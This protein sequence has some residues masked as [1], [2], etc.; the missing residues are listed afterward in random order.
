MQTTNVPP[1]DRLQVLRAHALLWARIAPDNHPDVTH[2]IQLLSE[3]GFQLQ[4]ARPSGSLCV[5]ALVQHAEEIERILASKPAPSPSVSP[6]PSVPPPAVATS[7]TLAS[8]NVQF[9]SMPS[10]DKEPE[11]FDDS[12]QCENSLLA[13]AKER[14]LSCVLS[15]FRTDAGVIMLEN[16]LILFQEERQEEVSEWVSRMRNEWSSRLHSSVLDDFFEALDLWVLSQL[17]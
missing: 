13:E 15:S 12:T 1:R 17:K 8:D 7:R 5:Q 9:H 2:M 10:L 3:M 4:H 16:D 14:L 11:P 6:P